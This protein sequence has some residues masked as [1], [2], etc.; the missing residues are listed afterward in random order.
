VSRFSDRFLGEA[1]VGETR[2]VSVSLRW[3]P[4]GSS[5]RRLV[6]VPV[7]AH[8][9]YD[10]DLSGYSDARVSDGL[11][12]I[13]LASIEHWRRYNRKIST[14]ESVEAERRQRIEELRLRCHRATAAPLGD[15]ALATQMDVASE[16]VRRAFARP[17]S[18]ASYAGVE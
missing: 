13:R 7:S 16:D 1:A 8:L 15:S 3:L 2:L 14:E 9:T 4:L 17:P 6:T 11:A 10:R 18:A 5:E 12:C